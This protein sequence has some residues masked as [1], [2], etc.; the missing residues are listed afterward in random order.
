MI[1]ICINDKD[2]PNEIPLSKWIKKG[3]EYNV[4]KADYMNMQNK[5]LGYQLQ[6]IDLSGCF[7]YLYFAASRFAIKEDKPDKEMVKENLLEL[8]EEL[9]MA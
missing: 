5:I 1:V 6:E 3:N 4:V 2:R 9:E 7:P 8:E